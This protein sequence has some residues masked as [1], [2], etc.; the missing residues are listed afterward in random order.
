MPRRSDVALALAFLV[1]AELEVAHAGLG[2]GAAVCAAAGSAGVAWRR[3]APV[4]AFFAVTVVAL[5]LDELISARWGEEA[6]AGVV[7][8]LVTSYALGAYAGR[9]ASVA[10]LAAG[11]AWLVAADFLLG[12]GDAAGFILFVVVVPW[13]SGRGVNAYRERAER[14]RE[15]T[16]RL[17]RERD[18]SERLSVARERER[19]AH[20][21]HDAIGHAVGVMTVQAAGAAETLARDPERARAALEAVQS[22]GRRAI[23]ELRDV[24]GVLRGDAPEPLPAITEPR[25]PWAPPPAAVDAVLVVLML[26]GGLASALA[27]S[28]YAGV[29]GPVLALQ[30]IACATVPARR[31]WPLAALAAALA[32]TVADSALIGADGESPA[33]IIA[34]LLAMYTVAATLDRPRAV[35]AGAAALATLMAASVA[36]GDNAIDVLLPLA[37]AGIPWL[38]GRGVAAHRRQAAELRVVAAR[39][40]RERDARARLAAM[41]ER[42]RVAREL[43]DSVAHG[44]S[45]MVL[46]AGAAELVL[47]SEPVKAREAARAV[48]AVGERALAELQ[49]LLGL[50]DPDGEAARVPAPGLEQLDALVESVSAAGLEVRVERHGVAVPLPAGLDGAAY[51]VVQE[52]LTNALKHSGAPTTVTLDYA[53]GGLRVRIADGGGGIRPSSG[54]GQGLIGMRERVAHH[55]GALSAGRQ[56]DGFAVEAWLPLEPEAVPA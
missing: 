10:A 23:A 6:N 55:G 53:A 27:T 25:E 50:L 9:R 14:L 11:L 22:T 30:A 19:M 44:V 42:A 21:V 18:M 41:A 54:A 33:P 32:C 1:A 39:L 29:R 34:V 15:M 36:V 47:D 46:Q 17:E 40:R 16:A 26:A 5:G 37:V 48:R 49:R 7:L 20:E 13:L 4:A 35:A 2:A 43:H 38:A 3:R 28:T 8:M 31:R 52:G 12:E 56:G 45:V 51:R 24:L